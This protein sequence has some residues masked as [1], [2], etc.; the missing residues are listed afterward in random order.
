MDKFFAEKVKE[1]TYSRVSE[2]YTNEL[3][4]IEAEIEHLST[5]DSNL[6]IYIREGLPL[7]TNL[8]KCYEEA[9]IE[10]KQKIIGSIFPNK[11]VFDGES[12]RTAQMNEVIFRLGSIYR[13]YKKAKKRKAAKN[14]SQSHCAPPLGLEPRTL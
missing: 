2:R 4:Q 9:T 12:Y 1:E 8:D 5:V 10:H 11:V 3:R 14:D 6:D 7:L 13:D